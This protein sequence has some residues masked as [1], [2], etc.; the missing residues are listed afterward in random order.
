MDMVSR[1]SRFHGFIGFTIG[2]RISEERF[3]RYIKRTVPM[4]FGRA[5]REVHLLLGPRFF[6]D[7]NAVLFSHVNQRVQGQILQL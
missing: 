2:I 6:S 3:L 1:V 7:I 4:I 5:A